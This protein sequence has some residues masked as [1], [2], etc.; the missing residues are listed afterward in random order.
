MDQINLGQRVA[1]AIGPALAPGDFA[2]AD[3]W[4]AAVWGAVKELHAAARG[5]LQSAGAG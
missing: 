5:R 3:S 4:V 1:V 2:D